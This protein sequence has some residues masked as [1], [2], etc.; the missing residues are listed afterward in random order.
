MNIEDINWNYQMNYEKEDF[1]EFKEYIQV[2]KV[3][4]ISEREYHSM[5]ARS[6]K[7][8]IV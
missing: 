1:I 7:W 8:Q 3:E 5:F 2:A 4:F 6:S